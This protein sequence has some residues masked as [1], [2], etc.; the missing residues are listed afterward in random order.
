MR[1]LFLTFISF[2]L[3]ASV[4]FGADNSRLRVYPPQEAMIFKG[5]DE[6][7]SPV[8]LRDGFSTTAENISFTSTNALQKRLGFDIVKDF[9]VAGID[10]EPV[11]GIFY[12]KFS[13]GT[14]YRIVTVGDRMRYET[15]GTWTNVAGSN[16]FTA[17]QNNQFVF[18]T[19]LDSVV[20]TN[21]VDK[22]QKWTAAGVPVALD[23]S[24]LSDA[25][26]KANAVVWFK[27]YL[28]LGNTTEACVI[29]PTRYRWCNVDTLK[30]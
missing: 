5:L 7:S 13:S 18:T 23:F 22:P 25:L 14:D 16:F 1:K 11:T 4:A 29:K 15:G 30:T 2:F 27:N 20:F 17:G 8:F 9:D 3:F 19:A 6:R 28:I 12:V 10:Y 21:N 26:T 24:G